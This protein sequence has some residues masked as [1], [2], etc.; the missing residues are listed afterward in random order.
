MKCISNIISIV[1]LLFVTST[2]AFVPFISSSN[3]AFAPKTLQ[4]TRSS[5]LSMTVLAYN[6]KKVDIKEGTPLKNACAKLGVK[7]KYSCKK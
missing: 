2:E 5:A 7:P 4:K 3:G 1:A 6:G